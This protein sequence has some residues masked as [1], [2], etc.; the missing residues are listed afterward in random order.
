MQI[1]ISVQSFCLG[2]ILPKV[3]EAFHSTGSHI[4]IHKISFRAR[5]NRR[6]NLY[7][8]KGLLQNLNLFVL[9]TRILDWK[10]AGI[11]YIKHLYDF[12]LLIKHYRRL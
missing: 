4:I 12:S 6:I 9:I 8:L 5:R 2:R 7:R 3:V 10:L 1:I 11:V